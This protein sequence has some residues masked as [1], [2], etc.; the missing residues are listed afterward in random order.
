MN[1]SVKKLPGPVGASRSR[2]DGNSGVVEILEQRASPL[3][4]DV[5]LVLQVLRESSRARGEGRESK[6]LPSMQRH[7]TPSVLLSLHKTNDRLAIK[8]SNIK[9]W[10]TGIEAFVI[11]KVSSKPLRR[12]GPTRSSTLCSKWH[13]FYDGNTRQRQ[14]K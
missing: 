4:G 7:S 9:K 2:G 3:L 8:T 5:H 11:Q 10:Y 12:R 6:K 1:E 13:T 14:R